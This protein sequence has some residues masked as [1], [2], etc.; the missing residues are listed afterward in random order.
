[1]S[2]AGFCPTCSGNCSRARGEPRSSGR[3]TVRAD[4]GPTVR[5]RRMSRLAARNL[6]ATWNE[7]SVRS[8]YAACPIDPAR[9]WTERGHGCS[10]CSPGISRRWRWR[11]AIADPLFQA[12]RAA[13]RRLASR[14]SRR[15]PATRRRCGTDSRPASD[16]FRSWT[17]WRKCRPKPSR[18][19]RETRRWAGCGRCC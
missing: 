4:R 7:T 3:L 13:D 19:S 12:A 2:T 14:A 1:M 17:S 18:S 16:P 15:R 6:A 11:A 8:G 5:R 10:Q 9:H